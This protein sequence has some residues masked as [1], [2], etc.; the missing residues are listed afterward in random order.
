MT[1]DSLVELA[2][3]ALTDMIISAALGLATILAVIGVF[4]WLER[5]NNA[6]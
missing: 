2:T 3:L 6:K 4:I 5:K 1:P